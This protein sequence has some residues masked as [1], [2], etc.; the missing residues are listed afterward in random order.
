MKLLESSSI[1]ESPSLALVWVDA[2]DRSDDHTEDQ[3]PANG[4][5]YTGHAWQVQW[6]L[7]VRPRIDHLILSGF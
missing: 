1:S 3:S 2:Y 6:S 7:L 4:F 5:E